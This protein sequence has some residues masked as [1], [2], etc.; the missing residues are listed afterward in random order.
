ME[1]DLTTFLMEVANFLIL[2]WI[3]NRLLYKP[4]Q[5]IIAKRQAA[6][7]QTRSEAGQ[8]RA[9]ATELE[10]TYQGRLASWDEEKAEL[11]RQLQA[12]IAIERQR[13]TAVLDTELAEMRDKVR[14]TEERQA[15][16]LVRLSEERAIT[17]AGRFA[18]RLLTRIAT[19]DLE[20]KLVEM[21]LEDLHGLPDEQLRAIVEALGR[22]EAIVRVVS[23]YPL[24]ETVAETFQE[25]FRAIFPA[26]QHFSFTVN[27]AL[28]AGIRVNTGPWNLS[29]NLKDELAF[30]LGGINGE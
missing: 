26:A 28:L 14:V 10:R 4:V 6:M 21:L 27:E 16:E 24:T 19:P 22:E 25:R 15:E 5:A 17:N 20:S 30:F 11:R 3:M 9:E 23:A 12:E 7:E 8:M 18:A 2:V 13:L 1:L 29:A